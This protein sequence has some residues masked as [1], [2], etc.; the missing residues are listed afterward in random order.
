MK[1][2]VARWFLIVALGVG[3]FL[4]LA[5]TT[6]AQTNAAPQNPNLASDERDAC[7]SNLKVIY[8]AIQAY[9]MDNKAVPNWLSDLVPQYL[10]DAN[11]LICPSCRRTGHLESAELSDPKLS[12]SYIYEFSPAP[13]G[14]L[15]PNSP[16]RTRREWRRRQMGLV[17]S[18]VPIVRCRH[19]KMVLNL[20]FD[21][22]IY[23]SPIAW[24]ETI[25]NRINVD[26]LS[27]AKLF[28]DGSAPS[29]SATSP[30]KPI[31]TTP[32]YPA[33]DPKTKA[34]LLNLGKYYNALLTEPW[35]GTPGDDL[36]ALPT[37]R[38]KL[39]GVEFDVRGVVQLG[40]KS[41]PG[42]NFP[43]IIRSIRVHQKCQRLYFLHAAGFGSAADEGKKIGT[44][45][46]HYTTNQMRLDIP[47]YY[48]KELRDWHQP[49]A[50]PPAKD[51]T[52][53][54][55]GENAAGKPL[56]RPIRL[57]MTTWVN[58]VPEFEI[59]RIDFSSTMAGPAPFLVAITAE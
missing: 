14:N 59:E 31:D 13:L 45:V 32:H 36:A 39:G 21:G 43:P 49:P 26:D 48:G 7:I 4:G 41:L 40:S 6:P 3:L 8:D 46:I 44:Y 20:S 34:A 33:R 11:V 58:L 38:Q 50:E 2:R 12:S 16:T 27:P 55:T 53:A 28:A 15:A 47:L 19:H 51:L 17:G 1:N 18:V 35:Q 9:Q 52:V 25:A 37:G 5:A 10:S 57:F 23:E 29:T 24:E 22:K 54:W 56:G 30:A 42:T